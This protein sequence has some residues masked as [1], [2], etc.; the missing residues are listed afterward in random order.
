MGEMGGKGDCIGWRQ[1]ESQKDG[2]GWESCQAARPTELF[3][4]RLRRFIV[5]DV[6]T[7]GEW[8][9]AFDLEVPVLAAE[10]DGKEVSGKS[11]PPAFAN[12]G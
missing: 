4:P 9:A 6:N 2:G 5:R 8:K 1:P 11:M 7:N 3:S 12:A 10:E